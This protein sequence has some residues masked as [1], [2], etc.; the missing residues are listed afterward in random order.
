MKRPATRR[1]AF[2]LVARRLADPEAHRQGDRAA[3]LVPQAV[4]RLYQAV[5][6]GVDPRC[7]RWVDPLWA[8]RVAQPAVL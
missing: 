7:R 6:A 4:C 1:E 5:V 3:G 8:A 2:P